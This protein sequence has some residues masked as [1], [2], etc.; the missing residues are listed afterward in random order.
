MPAAEP[1]AADPA[2]GIDLVDEEDARAVVLRR[3]EHVA[4]AAVVKQYRLLAPEECLVVAPAQVVDV[5]VEW[6]DDDSAHYGPFPL[7]RG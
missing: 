5:A 1:G 3:L 6:L 7:M 2:D 4:D